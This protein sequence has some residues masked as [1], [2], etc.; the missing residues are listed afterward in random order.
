MGVIGGCRKKE[1][2]RNFWRADFSTAAVV[3]VTLTQCINIGL[4]SVLSRRRP[5]HLEGKSVFILT[6]RKGNIYKLF[7]V[8]G[9][10]S[11]QVKTRVLMETQNSSSSLLKL[12]VNFY[13]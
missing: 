7:P 5:R 3:S 12:S 11:G 9:S 4:C 8:E 6:C 2:G 13:T 1:S 10:P